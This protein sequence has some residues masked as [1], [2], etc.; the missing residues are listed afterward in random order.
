MR[1]KVYLIFDKTK[2]SL[3]IKSILI[4]KVKITSLI[5]SNI[6]IVLGGDGFMLQTL[7][8]LH[9]Y[10][11]PFYG[12]NSGNY[13]FLMNK[14]SNE[15]I[16]KNLNIS[17]SIKIYPLQMTVTNKNNQTKKSIAINEVS[18]L[19]QSKQASSIS[20]IANKKNI[21]KNPTNNFEIIRVPYTD[22]KKTLNVVSNLKKAYESKGKT[23]INDFEKNISLAI[24]DDA[25]KT[26]L[27][28]MDELK[29]SVQLAVHEQ[30]DPLLIYKFEAF[31]LFK[32]MI[33]QV[34]KDVISFLFKGELPQENQ[35]QIREAR[36]EKTNKNLKEQKDEI[37]N[38]DERSSVSRAAG[39]TQGQQRQITETIVREQP[40]IGRNDKVT[41]KHVMNGEN[42]TLKYK[43]AIP[44]INKGEW[45]LVE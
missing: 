38:L 14:F 30:K 19:R 12:I 9:K 20:I 41:I 36:Q 7:K 43:Q 34:N 28:K 13:G 27:R 3:K 6:I 29:Q 42:K 23:L 8:K 25:W 11:K 22:G 40:K 35:Q 18:I 17:N 16:I 10:K 37:Q 4:K 21:I 32:E 44:L 33:V 45:V 26:H 39:Q 1:D 24:I 15:N 5:K 2:A 31:E